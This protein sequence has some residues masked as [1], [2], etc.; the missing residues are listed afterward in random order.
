MLANMKWIKSP[1]CWPIMFANMIGRG[2]V[3][4]REH[5]MF[6]NMKPELALTALPSISSLQSSMLKWSKGTCGLRFLHHP[7]RDSFRSIFQI[8][9]AEC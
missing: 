6:A 9:F 2:M 7:F 4:V 3:H 8:F 5:A 1:S